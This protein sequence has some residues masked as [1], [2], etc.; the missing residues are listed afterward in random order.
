MPTLTQSSIDTLALP[1]VGMVD[2]IK[3]FYKNPE[4]ERAYREWHKEKYGSY[5]SDEV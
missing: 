3:E 2:V 1:L 5:P 4:N